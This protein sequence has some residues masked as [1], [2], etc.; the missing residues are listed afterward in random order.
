M[1]LPIEF[2]NKANAFESKW[3]NTPHKQDGIN[4]ADGYEKGAKD[5]LNA[6]EAMLKESLHIE[7]ININFDI[8]NK[9]E[10]DKTGGK[11]EAISYLLT[12]LQSIKPL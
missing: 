12:N 10:Q 2:L 9:A 7:K 3:A 11:I 5:M 6:V 4:L 1:E 8:F